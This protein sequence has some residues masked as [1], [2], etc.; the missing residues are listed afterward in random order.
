MEK[1]QKVVSEVSLSDA[2]FQVI[3]F[4]WEHGDSPTYFRELV[5]NFPNWKKQT[6]NTIV[7]RLHDKGAIRTE[8]QESNNYK[9]YSPVITKEAYCKSETQALVK[10]FKER[11]G[12][13]SLDMLVFEIENNKDN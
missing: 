10:T 7:Y 8:K 4:M 12:I 5:S 6:I 9:Q 11:Y 2:E 1:M 3:N 13:D